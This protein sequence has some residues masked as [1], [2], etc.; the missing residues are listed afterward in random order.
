[1]KTLNRFFRLTKAECLALVQAFLLLFFLRLASLTLPFF[2]VQDFLHRLIKRRHTR[3]PC[4][5]VETLVWGV[6]V[7]GAYILRPTCLMQALA[8]YT[9]LGYYGKATRLVIGVAHSPAGQFQ[10]HAWVEYSGTTII[11]GSSVSYHPLIA[12]N[13][14]STNDIF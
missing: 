8:V 10:A 13:S 4:P 1:M 11:G 7:A 12:F 9:L 14:G 2:R 6:T 3:R 5:P